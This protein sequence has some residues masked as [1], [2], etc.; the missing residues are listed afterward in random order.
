[1][2]NTMSLCNDYNQ[3]EIFYGIIIVMM[4]ISKRY[5]PYI[6]NDV[7]RRKINQYT[8]WNILMMLVNSAMYN[9]FA[10]DNHII[11]RFI[12]INSFQIM[13]LF[14]LF[15][16]YDSNVLFC[17]MD[18]KPVLLQHAVFRS[19]SNHL[20]V[21]AEYFVANI[22][23]H[24]LPVY[25]YRDYLVTKIDMDMFHYI[26]MFKFM[27]VLNI[28]GDFNITSIYVPTFSGCNVKLVNLVVAIDFLTYKVLNSFL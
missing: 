3:F 13:T 12:A 8:N 25:F 1:M 6:K 2:S 26:I 20:L 23:V 15:M 24:I 28:F 16:V 17:V 19:I 9:I 5:A 27:W 14:H 22:V 11:S 21:R 7:V 4:P 18:A 10:M